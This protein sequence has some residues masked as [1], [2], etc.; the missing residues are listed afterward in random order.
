MILPDPKV[1][2]HKGIYVVRDDLIPGGTKTRYL[3]HLFNYYDEVVYATPAYGGA[4]LALAYAA[5][6]KGKRVTLFVAKRKKPHPRT[7]EA[8]KKGARVFQVPGGYLNV[9][10]S[11]AKKYARDKG[12]FYLSFGG[13][14][15][16]TISKIGEA[17]ANVNQKHGPFDQVWCAAGSGV[18]TRGLQQGLEAEQFFAVQVGKDLTG[19]TG[20]AKVIKNPL[21]FEKEL[22][23]DAPFPACPNYD[24]KAWK[25]CF[26]K[27]QGK[28]LFWNVL[29]PSPTP[30]TEKR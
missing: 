24:R 12:A 3:M 16:D 1:K 8:K 15:E 9:V 21:P 2:M 5:L 22:K 6:M 25:L 13:D 18:L 28:V 4:Q 17:A 23:D 30:F 29:G 7:L 14:M 11:K 20:K 19:K 26:E 10:Q 27:S